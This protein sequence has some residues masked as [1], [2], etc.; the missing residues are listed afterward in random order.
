MKTIQAALTAA[1]IGFTLFS[2]GQKD[3]YWMARENWYSVEFDTGT[4][5]MEGEWG[6]DYHKVNFKKEKESKLAYYW[7]VFSD[8]ENV[9][10]LQNP[11]AGSALTSHQMPMGTMFYVVDEKDDYLLVHSAESASAAN[12]QELGWIHKNNLLVWNHP[13]KGKGSGIDIKAFIV[14]TKEYLRSV[15]DGQVKDSKEIYKIYNSPSSS[16]EIA[17]Q[18][19]YSILFVFKYDPVHRRYLVSDHYSLNASGQLTGWVKEERIKLWETSLALE[20]NFDEDAVEFRKIE[21]GQFARVFKTTSQTDDFIAGREVKPLIERD[22]AKKGT[23]DLVIRDQVGDS[24]RHVRFQGQLPRFPMYNVDASSFDCGVVG[25][26]NLGSDPS[27]IKGATDE[28]LARAQAKFQDREKGLDYTN[29]VFVIETSPG[30][31]PYIDQIDKIK[32]DIVRSCTSSQEQVSIKWGFVAYSDSWCENE[33]AVTKICPATSDEE[34]QAQMA[35][36]SDVA[37]GPRDQVEAAA[38][39]L[40][41]ALT[42]CQLNES[43]NNIVIHMGSRGDIRN[44]FDR[45]GICPDLDVPDGKLFKRFTELSAHYV[46]VQCTLEGMDEEDG[47]FIETDAQKIIENVSRRMYDEVRE[48]DFYAKYSAASAPKI[49]RSDAEASLSIEDNAVSIMRGI[50]P[51]GSVTSNGQIVLDLQRMRQSVTKAI[52]EA[53]DKAKAEMDLIRQLYKDNS[54]LSDMAADFGDIGHLLKSAGLSPEEIK[55]FTK[56]R[57]QLYWNGSAPKRA[58]GGKDEMWKL[59]LFIS[60]DDVYDIK[61]RLDELIAA[62]SA[63]DRS[64]RAEQVKLF[65]EELAFDVLNM[66]PKRSEVKIDEIRRNM[67]GLKKAGVELGGGL[68]ENLTLDDIEN[69][70]PAEIDQYLDQCSARGPFWDEVQS[71]YQFYYYPAG[72]GEDRKKFFWIPFEFIF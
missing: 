9:D 17:T 27:I 37:A 6:N 25:K 13:Y 10:I 7:K 58:P 43:E 18:D 44:D 48:K 35:Q 50:W 51:D 70:P 24:L 28:R 34:F 69:L 36:L 31:Q 55:I 60:E 19:L 67:L 71:S 22:V 41:T 26:L 16:Q 63:A 30:M 14:N 8:R 11:K 64:K 2:W 56:E 54:N 45:D 66:D 49:I 61:N 53:R 20:P 33:S 4:Q 32:D 1:L 12:N 65:W 42:E 57:V 3:P 15:Q 23:E 29:I 52:T 40:F 59:V 39:G 21:K 68:L 38:K 46:A 5:T 62:K 72:E 47:W